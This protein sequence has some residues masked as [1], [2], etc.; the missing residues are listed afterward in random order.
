MYKN[1]TAKALNVQKMDLRG[2]KGVSLVEE[3]VQ[4]VLDLHD[5][6]RVVS[7]GSLLE[8]DL[9]TDLIRFLRQNQD[10]FAWSH[11]DMPG[12]DPQVMSYRLNVDPG[13]RPVKQ[14]R[15]GMAPERQEAVREE[16]GKLLKAE[17]VR[18][19]HYLDRKSTRLN[20]SH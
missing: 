1:A 8:P 2:E 15:R 9:Q 5:P 17:S 4:I 13:F 16:V 3:L 12:I 11:Q 7:I 10:V 6:D 19:V 20:S 14:K 18:E